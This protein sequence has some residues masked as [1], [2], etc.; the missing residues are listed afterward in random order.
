MTNIDK[1]LAE[2][3]D[4][5]YRESV[6]VDVRRQIEDELTQALGVNPTQDGS[7]TKEMSGYN[8]KVTTRLTRKVDADKLQEIA[9]EH[10]LTEHLGSLFRWKPEIDM[11]AW[12]SSGEE[13]TKPLLQ[14][15]TTTPGR[16]SYSINAI[17]TKE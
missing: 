1:L 11:K 9:A 5:K 15:I 12:K 2:W 4:A 6:A 16:P 13:I 3:V 7:L 17:T 10:G 8:V 14:A